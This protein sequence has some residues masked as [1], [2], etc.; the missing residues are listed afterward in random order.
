VF[1][2]TI[3]PGTTRQKLIPALEDASGRTAG[4]DFYVIYNPEYLR[5]SAAADFAT[6]RILTCGSVEPGD[7]ASEALRT[8][9][10]AWDGALITE[11]PY[12]E[13][14]FQTYV[15]NIWT[16][17]KIS[18]F[19]ERDVPVSGS[20]SSGWTRSSPSPRRRLRH[21]GT[22]PSARGTSDPT[23]APAYRRTRRHGR[24]SYAF[25]WSG[26]TWST[27]CAASMSAWGDPRPDPSHLTSTPSPAVRTEGHQIAHRIS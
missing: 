20:T 27:Q 9:F 13:A 15:H 24:A 25:T 12:E 17:I 8:L 26:R 16:A 1:R 23:E 11:L 22:R 4:I 2:S 3:P 6:F 10:A 21:R 14:E 5:D 7:P 18:Y 19:N